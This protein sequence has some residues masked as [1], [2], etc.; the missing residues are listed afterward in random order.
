MFE[1]LVGAAGSVGRCQGLH[2]GSSGS[3]VSNPFG[4]EPLADLLI[5][6]LHV[7]PRL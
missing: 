4:S 1:Q 2:D 5:E 7:V 3:G 6:R